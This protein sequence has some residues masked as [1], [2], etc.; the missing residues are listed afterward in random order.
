MYI[1]HS[2]MIFAFKF[3]AEMLQSHPF[4]TKPITVH[5]ITHTLEKIIQSPCF[6]EMYER[7]IA[8]RGSVISAEE[9]DD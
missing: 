1:T 8:E 4:N 5:L 6:N 7:E 9:L 2:Q 3:L